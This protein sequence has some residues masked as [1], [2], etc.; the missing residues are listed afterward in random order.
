MK[1][2]LDVLVQIFKPNGFDWM[3][4]ALSKNNPYTYHHIIKK[5]DGGEKSVDNGAI[6]TKKAHTFL[7]KLEKVCPDAYNDL[8]EVFRKI[9]GSKTPPN[10]EIID[11]IDNI[12][13]RLLVLGEYEVLDNEVDL[14]S[15]CSHYCAGHKQLKKC[16]K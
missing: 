13:Y 14:S 7:N 2:A 3:N 6:L 16:L 1:G 5:C 8:Q 11:E 10:D 12:L 15:Y 9:N 4:F